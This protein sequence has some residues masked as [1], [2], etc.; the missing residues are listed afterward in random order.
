MLK[1]YAI[2]NGTAYMIRL[3]GPRSSWTNKLY[4]IAVQAQGKVFPTEAEAQAW[5]NE[6]L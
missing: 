3:A 2:N 4:G 6:R 5:V 1:I